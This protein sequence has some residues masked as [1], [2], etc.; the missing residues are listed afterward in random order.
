MDDGSGEATA[1]LGMDGF[2][3]LAMTGEDGEWWLL[4]ET[5]A[6]PVGCPSCGVQAT[7]HGRSVVQVRDLPVSGRP[8]RLCWRKRRWRCSDPDCATNTFS[9][10]SPLVEGALTRR[11]R[12]E[13]CRRVGEDGHSVAS[14]ARSFGIGWASAMAA[15]RDHGQPLVEAAERSGVV[16]ALGVD[17]HKMLSAGP[18]HRAVFATQLVDLDTG[19]LL[20][21]VPSRSGR[22]VSSWLEAKGRGFCDRVA[23]AAIDPHAGYQRAIRLTL[24]Q[25]TVTVDP[26]HLIKLANACI[27]DVRRRVQRETLGHRGRK[28]DPLYGIRRLL[29]RGWERLSDRQEERLVTALHYGDPFD[30]VGAALVAKE[31]LRQMYA[32]GSLHRARRH[33]ASFYDRAGRAGVPEVSRLARTVKRWEAQILS[34]FVTGRTNARSEAANLVT[35]KLRRIAHGMRNFDNYR[36]RLLLHSGVEWNTRS[37]ARIRGRQPRLI[38]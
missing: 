36:L 29:T 6:A 34:F 32:A 33:L 12:A 30:E 7:G 20:G 11:A 28:D 15:V 4:V 37:T 38:A 27:D 19:R 8:V 21:V 18:R 3:V 10:H 17:E 35:E 23:V 13:I 5:T 26:F 9:E 1:L 2:I 22:A 31:E 25:A 16:R 14:V 24:P